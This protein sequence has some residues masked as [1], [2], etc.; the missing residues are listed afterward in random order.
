M[1]CSCY[2]SEL[3]CFYQRGKTSVIYRAKWGSFWPNNFHHYVNNTTYQIRFFVLLEL[4][5]VQYVTNTFH[6]ES[7]YT[8]STEYL[9]QCVNV[10]VRKKMIMRKRKSAAWWK[11]GGGGGDDD[12]DMCAF[13]F[14]THARS[15]KCLSKN[16]PTSTASFPDPSPTFW[17]ESFT[18]IKAPAPSS[19]SVYSCF[20]SL[21]LSSS[22]CFPWY[23]DPWNL[24][25]FQIKC[26]WILRIAWHDGWNPTDFGTNS[27]SQAVSWEIFCTF[28]LHT[29]SSQNL[30]RSWGL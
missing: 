28:A 1:D 25:S 7:K 5:L 23:Q 27:I 18:W 15:R 8:R 21:S 12:D 14:I 6:L 13:G 11:G 30:I 22:P 10:S 26:E 2:L 29:T 19:D 17:K 9:I 24:H 3:T 16:S 20:F 4:F